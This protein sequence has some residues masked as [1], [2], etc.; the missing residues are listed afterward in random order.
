MRGLDVANCILSRPQRR[1]ELLVIVDTDIGHDPDGAFAL[2]LLARLC[3]NL[4]VVTC[5]ETFGRRALMARRLL[6]AMG[7]TDVEVI[8]GIG[9]L[10]RGH[11]RFRVHEDLLAGTRPVPHVPLIDTLAAR[12]IAAEG[13]VVWIGQGSMSTLAYLLTAKPHLAAKIDITQTGGWLDRYHDTSRSEHN[14]RTDALAAQTALRL[15]RRPRLVLSDHTGVPEL[16]IGPDSA[17]Y[18]ELIAPSAPEWAQLIGANCTGWWRYQRNRDAAET[19][20]M[21]DPLTASAALG[22]EFVSFA[23][24]CISIDEA[25]MTRRDPAGVEVLVSIDADQAGFMDRL[26][27]VVCP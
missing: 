2:A 20:N 3:K 12:I 7:R 9:G 4:L 11:H 8:E 16:A 19:T 26:Y 24:E 13:R 25:A 21:H 6:D 5:D 15:A 23:P 22:E 17:L 1:A 10:A 18:Q 14:F 27:E